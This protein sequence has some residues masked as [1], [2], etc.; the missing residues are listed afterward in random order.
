MIFFIQIPRNSKPYIYLE[1]LI[2]PIDVATLTMNAKICEFIKDCSATT[3]DTQTKDAIQHSCSN[4][5]FSL[6]RILRIIFISILYVDCKK[7][8][9]L[10]VAASLAVN[11]GYKM[12]LTLGVTKIYKPV[13]KICKP[14]ISLRRILRII[15][16][17]FLFCMLT[18]EK[19]LYFHCINTASLAVNKR[20]KMILTLGVTLHK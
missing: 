3:K 14:M 9:V 17:I 12:I 13:R 19:S 7:V 4:Q 10:F 1:D 15:H 20:Y 5:H 16:S 11:N 18:V 8:T 6:S 2:I